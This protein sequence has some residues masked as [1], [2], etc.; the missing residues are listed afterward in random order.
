MKA[1]Y[2]DHMGDDDAVVDAAR[3]SLDKVASLFPPE[4]NH[5]LIRFLARGCTGRDWNDLIT[6][7][8][9]TRD[10]ERVEQ[11]LNQVRRMPTHWTPFGHCTIKLRMQAPVPMR[12]QSFKHKQGFV[13]N[14]ESRRY[15]KS[16]PELFIPDY[17]RASAD[18]VKQ[19]SGDAHPDSKYWRSNYIEAAKHAIALYEDMVEDHVCPEQARFVLPQGVEVNWMW[20]G[21][22]FAF[23]SFVVKRTDPHVQEETRQ[24]AYE[25]SDIIEPLFPVS[26]DAL[27]K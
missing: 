18:D 27:T 6:E 4:D 22:L 25:V 20:T 16:T 12:T 8:V 24:L 26:W 2:V 13:E 10:T 17:F 3:I 5:R 7:L 11:V 9:E 23:A 15:I 21:S 1:E 19:G 14:E